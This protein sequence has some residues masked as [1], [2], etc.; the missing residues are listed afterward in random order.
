M[1]AGSKLAATVIVN[2]TS[3]QS[4]EFAFPKDD[5]LSCVLSVQDANG[6]D[7]KET[8]EGAR[9]REAYAAWQGPMATYVLRPGE[10]QT[11]E[12]PVSSLF[13]ISNPG[14]YSITVR[15]LDGR[16]AASNVATITILP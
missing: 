15:E 2:N 12:C 9:M 3:K 6:K 7:V 10:K 5:P 1:K 13:D 11:R 4:L 8:Q 14:K 16:P